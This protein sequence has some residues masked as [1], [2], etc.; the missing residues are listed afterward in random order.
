MITFRG[1][2]VWNQRRLVCSYESN[3]T[4]VTWDLNLSGRWL[5]SLPS[6][7]LSTGLYCGVSKHY[8]IVYS[9]PVNSFFY[10]TRARYNWCQGPVP[11]RGPTVEKHRPTVHRRPQRSFLWLQPPSFSSHLHHRV[12]TKL[13]KLSSRKLLDFVSTGYRFLGL[14]L[15]GL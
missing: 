11:G 13:L 15:T 3:R 14:G 5:W 10:K 8:M 7:S 12:L 2:F 1:W 4:M 9:G 6:I